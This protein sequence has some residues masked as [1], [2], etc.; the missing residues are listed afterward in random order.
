[1]ILY[2]HHRRRRRRR[3]QYYHRYCPIWRAVLSEMRR[4]HPFHPKKYGG[5]YKMGM[6][7]IWLGIG[8]V[9]VECK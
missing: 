2:S 3:R 4:R 1:M 9:T 5:R 7:Q 8:F 6:L